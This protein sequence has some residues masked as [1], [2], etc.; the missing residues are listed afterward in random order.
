[1]AK[2]LALTAADGLVVRPSLSKTLV[3]R[4]AKFKRFHTTISSLD[5]IQRK[6]GRKRQDWKFRNRV[7]FKAAQLRK[8]NFL[9]IIKLLIIW[10]YAIYVSYICKKLLPVPKQRLNLQSRKKR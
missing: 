3:A 7:G 8:V 10:D 1:M 2:D 4:K 5:I 9:Y 6:K